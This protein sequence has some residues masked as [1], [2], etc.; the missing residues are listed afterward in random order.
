MKN[1]TIIFFLLLILVSC[2]ERRLNFDQG[3][4]PPVATNFSVVNSVYDDYN[5]DLEITWAS[6][7]FSLIFSSS[8]NSLGDDFDFVGY[9][10]DIFFDLLT[11]D[12]LISARDFN[13]EVLDRINSEANEFGPYFTADYDSNPFRLHK[14]GGFQ[15]LIYTS[16]IEANQDI[17]CIYYNLDDPPDFISDGDVFPVASI[18]TEFNEAYLT[19]HKGEDPKSEVA[20]FCSDRDGTWDIWRAAGEEG[21]LI[22][23]SAAADLTKVARLS[24]EADE[25]CPYVS[26]NIMV[27]ASD[28]AGG[29]GGFDLWYSLYDGTAWSEPVNFGDEI[30]TE[31]DEFRP[32]VVQAE[33]G[34]FMND[35]MIFSSNR[36]GGMG[37]FDLYYAGIKRFS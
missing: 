12:F 6:R 19:I 9:R 14:N 11:G 7:E 10:G 15:R 5:S 13:F 1:E 3:I 16:D 32:V 27:F 36:P 20:Y 29:H 34:F 23:E 26:G 24:G 8:R 31:Y 18:N 33:D 2:D 30:N 37:G 35:L 22:S 17:Y 4:I 21:K 28:R 25:K